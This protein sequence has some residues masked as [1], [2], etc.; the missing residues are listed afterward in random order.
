MN[1]YKD[2]FSFLMV[3]LSFSLMVIP[4]GI[5][6]AKTIEEDFDPLVDIMVTFKLLAIRSLEKYDNQLHERE[7]IDRW[8][9]PDFY[10]KVWINDELRK[11]KIWWNTRYV[12]D[13]DF[14]FTVDVPDDEELVNIKIQLWDWNLGVDQLCDISNDKT[15]LK[16]ARDVE[17]IYSIKYG[18]WWGDDFTSSDQIGGDPSGYGRLNGC[19]D[20]SIYQ[21]DLDCELWF[22]IYQNDF[23]N[24][25]I[26]YWMESNVYGT[27]PTINNAMDDPDE[28]GVPALWEYTFG[29]YCWQDWR[30]EEWKHE[31]IYNPFEWD[32]HKQLD[33]DNDGLSNFEEYLTW[34]WGSEPFRKDLFIEMDV[35][36]DGP[37]GETIAFPEESKELLQTVYNRRNIVYHLDDGSMGGGERIPF[38][39]L[40]SYNELQLIYD[41]YFLHMDQD[42]WRKGV[43]HYGLVINE[44]EGAYGFV[45]RRN[46]YQI[47]GVGMEK[48]AKYPQLKRDIV[49]AS[50]YMHECGHTLGI[51]H[52]NT[53]GCD[54][55]EGKYPW[56][57]NWWK[58][59]PYKSV[60]NYG[61]M[62][63]ILDYSD[64]SRGRNDFDD[65]NRLDFTFFQ[66]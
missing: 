47:S 12:Y 41:R 23:D 5:S 45:F 51:F 15:F 14:S 36:E 65:W 4:T 28:D 30:T 7:Y 54:D 13:P 53:P 56:Q 58:W 46:A 9:G 44:A 50:A 16:D 18:L 64:G 1:A 62:Y 24:D 34:Q 3:A 8:T 33:P 66:S 55:Q 22:T 29:H 2:F 20:G 42:N 10:V 52:G 59:H 35:M 60:M 32:D 49:Y 48:K 11:S 27:D 17:L 31:W 61:Y 21:H 37:N 40:S 39:T 25:M 38:D 43:F 26:P 63:W 19:D 57:L 6:H